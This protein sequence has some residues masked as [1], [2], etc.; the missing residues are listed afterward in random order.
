MDTRVTGSLVIFAFY[1]L[2]V[3]GVGITA[4]GAA[5]VDA[6]PGVG[7]PTLVSNHENP[8]GDLAKLD[9]QGRTVWNDSRWTDVFGI[10]TMP[11]D[12]VLIA[13]QNVTDDCGEWEA[14]CA[15]TGVE[16]H[17]QPPGE[18][19]WRWA[20]KTPEEQANEMHDAEY[21]DT[22]GEVSMIDMAYERL[23]VVDYPSGD[24]VWQWNASEFYS[25]PPEPLYR[26]WLHMND[27]DRLGEDRWLISV[28]NANQL[29]IVERGEGVV[30]VI[31]K[32]RDDSNDDDC[33]GP[34]NRQL[35][36]VDI[37]CGDLL[38]MDHQHD[39]QW[40]GDGRVLVADSEKGRLVELERQGDDWVPVWSDEGAGGMSYQWPRDAN[41][42]PNGH[43][44]V[45]DTRN[46]RVVEL[47]EDGELYWET[48]VAPSTYAALR[49]GV[50][51]RYGLPTMNGVEPRGFVQ[52]IDV[53][54]VVHG[55][56]RHIGAIPRW[57][58]EWL[59]LGGAFVVFLNLCAVSG[60][61]VEKAVSRLR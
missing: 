34:P 16:V 61:G 43:T 11:N 19:Q 23:V 39:P 9:A 57:F 4:P 51:P 60:V 59:F 50:E 22:Y 1:L 32:D 24:V 7:G 44:V 37:T 30:E 53:I 52:P 28:R 17:S 27:V 18:R 12:S 33:R 55:G 45:V 58:N 10:D 26:D 35:Y 48:P 3:A 56:A 41:R 20:F 15:Y 42:L 46:N 21:N 40:L 47:D 13:F 5:S 36:G 6:N 8:S 49:D 25:A 54:S 29:L 14:P 31:N 38:V 2:I